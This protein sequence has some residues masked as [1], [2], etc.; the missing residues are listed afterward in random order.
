MHPLSAQ[1]ALEAWERGQ[2]YDDLGRA[3]SLLSSALPGF[4]RE[5]L[6]RLPVGQR[7]ALLIRLQEISF[8]HEILGFAKCPQCN[9]SLEFALDTRSYDTANALQRTLTPQS[10]TLDP[11]RIRFRVPDSLDLATAGRNQN[12]EGARRILIDRCVLA[13]FRGDE[14]VAPGDLPDDILEQIGDQMEALDPMAELP[15]DIDCARCGHHWRNLF[16]IGSL[17]WDQVSSMAKRLLYD[18]QALARAYGWGET[19]ILNMSAARRKF[20]LEQIPSPPR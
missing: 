12:L 9:A 17:M 7:D 14:A 5:Q 18:V 4:A 16:D 20:Y 10:L 6:A 8:G 1:Q 3:L 15:I 2:R 19:E 13:A 11:Y